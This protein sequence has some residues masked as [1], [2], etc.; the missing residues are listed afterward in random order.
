ML[1]QPLIFLDLEITGMT[2]THERIT[3]IGLV[4]IENGEFVSRWDQRGNCC[5]NSTPSAH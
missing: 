1:P 3:E 2:A 5:R 4:E